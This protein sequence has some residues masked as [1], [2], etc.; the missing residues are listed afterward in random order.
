M[1]NHIVIMGRLTRDPELRRTGSGIAVASFTVAVDRDFG[2]R[3]GGEKETD[4]IDCVAWRQTGEFVSKYFPKGSMMVVAG[5]LQIRNWTDKEG[6]KRRSAEVVADN[7]YFGDSRRD[8][9]SQDGGYVPASSGYSSAPSSYAPPA[10]QS[11]GSAPVSDFAELS[12]DDGE[13]PF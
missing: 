5:R 13:L 12:D 10:N 8:G 1:L 6:N 9:D 2:G 3:D 7:V 11:F 4:F